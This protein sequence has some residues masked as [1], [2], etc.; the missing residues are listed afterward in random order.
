MN[1]Y[2][3]AMNIY[4]LKWTYMY[5][6]E[7]IF[8]AMNICL[9]LWT[10]ILLIGSYIYWNEYIFTEMNIYLMKWIQLPAM[11][12]YL[13]LWIYMLLLRTYILLLWALTCIRYIHWNEHTFS[14]YEHIFTFRNIFLYFI[15][16]TTLDTAH[17]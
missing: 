6:Y 13:Q 16:I 9:L 15:N 4:L 7:H 10:Y 12:I 5:C 3:T 11:N 17:V 2:F 8:N 14:T 1:I